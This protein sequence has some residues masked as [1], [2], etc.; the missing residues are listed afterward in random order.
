MRGV[1]GTKERT[2]RI[3]VRCTPEEKKRIFSE[4]KKRK[5]T[6]TEFLVSAALG[7]ILGEALYELTER[8]ED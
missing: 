2:E 1:K 7:V 3:D 6:V 4:A 8:K 5:L